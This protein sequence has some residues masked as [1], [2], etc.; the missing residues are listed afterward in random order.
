MVPLFCPGCRCWHGDP[1]HD[2]AGNPRGCPEC[3]SLERHRLLAVL[4]PVLACLPA[5]DE[6]G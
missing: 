6:G 5:P 4:L 2:R 1:I 3:Y